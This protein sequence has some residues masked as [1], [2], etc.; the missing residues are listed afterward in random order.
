MQN[1]NDQTFSCFWQPSLRLSWAVL[2]VSGLGC[3][4]AFSADISW[5][6]RICVCLTLCGSILQ[7]LY[8]LKYRQ[9]PQLRRGL[10][11]CPQGWHIWSAKQG[12]QPIQL[13]ADSM[14]TPAL[15]LVR[16]RH[17]WQKFYRSALVPADSLPQDSHRGLRLRLKFSRQ[18]WQ[19]IK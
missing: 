3:F 18:R 8:L 5:T 11:H 16:Y 19:G 12:W 7:Q 15:V 1:R 6:L 4:A 10:R 13:R 9:T 14:A 2:L 17:R